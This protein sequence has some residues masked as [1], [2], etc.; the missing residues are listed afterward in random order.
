M[1]TL[2][3]LKT[4]LPSEGVHYLVTIR[5]YT[6]RDGVQRTK[7][8]HV[9]FEYLSA[10]AEAIEQA[11]ENPKPG[12]L[13]VYHACASYLKDEVD[14]GVW[15]NGEP[16]PA[17]RVPENHNR[18]KAIWIDIDCGEDKAAEGKG[19][20][21][22]RDAN[23]ALIEFC[24]ATSLPAPLVVDSGGGLHCYWPLTKAIRH[25]A[26]KRLS[27]AFK[28]LTQA[29]GLL[30]DPTA[31]AD[32]A[33]ILRPVGSHN[34]KRGDRR[35]VKAVNPETFH[36]ISP[37]DLLAAITKVRLDVGFVVPEPNREYS[38]S[39]DLDDLISKGKTEFPPF[40][41][42]TAAESCAQIRQMRDMRGDVSYDHWRGV[43]GFIKLSTDEDS[44]AHT[45][46][47]EREATGHAQT[48]VGAKL[49]S[50]NSGPPTCEYFKKCN[51]DGCVGCSFDGKVKSPARLGRVLSVHT[52]ST[53]L[54]VE[55]PSI[56]RNEI[57]GAEESVEYEGKKVLVE[58]PP[59]PTGYRWDGQRIV[60]ELRDKDG[61]P[62]DNAVTNS[63]MWAVSRVK[64][65]DHKMKILMR[66]LLN[67]N[68]LR[69]FYVGADE[70]AAGGT[71]LAKALGAYEIY[72]STENM[73]STN[74]LT[75]YL[76]D[77]AEN[78]KRRADE[79]STY[80]SYGWKEDYDLLVMGNK[81]FHRD[82][83]ERL[84]ILSGG[85]LVFEEG[86]NK[87]TGSAKGWSTAINILYN[88][89]GVEAFQY[90]IC[91]AFG[92]LLGEFQDEQYKGIPVALTST[93]SG[94]GKSTVCKMALYA[95]GDAEELSL[96]TQNG[97]TVLARDTMMGTLKNLPMLIDEITNID[98]DQLSDFLY[99]S[100]NGKSKIRLQS[101]GGAVTLRKSLSWNTSIFLT[102]N[103]R[104]GS[105]LA[106][107][108]A[109]STAEAV[110]V[111]EIPMDMLRA[112]LLEREDFKLAVGT[113][114]R[115]AGHAG[116][117]YAR[118]LVQNQETVQKYMVEEAGKMTGDGADIPQ[119]RFFRMHVECTIVA[120]R[121]MKEIG[122]VDFDIGA[123][124]TWAHGHVDYLCGTVAQ[125]NTISPEDAL[126]Q[127][128]SSMSPDILVTYGFKSGRDGSE[129]AVHRPRGE[130]VGR[131]ILG[132]RE[133]ANMAGQLYLS[134]K[135][136]RD[137]CLLNR[138]SVD[139]IEQAMRESGALLR[140]VDDRIR[141]TR[142]VE[143]SAVQARC[144]LIDTRKLPGAEA[145]LSVVTAEEV[146]A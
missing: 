140:L 92:S 124:R 42:E 78:L 43:I 58:I 21:T 37:E 117:D 11:D 79:V 136:V 61:L 110:R 145:Q 104:I 57:T 1:D 60:R 118:W 126:H 47:S 86:L 26:W 59:M 50:W 18:A 137:W 132:N 121:I 143:M 32:F 4:I 120:A 34:T 35:L 44:L 125:N 49:N 100:S 84:V 107:A 22:K 108:K 3:F 13:G 94:L 85:A 64:G 54:E 71:T 33:R 10:M 55:A 62:T 113:V 122:L 17:Y 87:R 27:A 63:R 56:T 146:A 119:Y 68:R 30:A 112:P 72:P 103:K 45:W 67:G 105:L 82:G 46:S 89:P 14:G 7:T 20:A 74:H 12:Q 141:I 41:A 142:G 80:E 90:A 28:A 36:Y 96:N 115:N 99:T 66:M 134:K 16:K 75:A 116:E 131:Y 39:S 24:R 8:E 77:E 139:V 127:M 88:R 9:P 81:A 114:K 25:Q 97:C 123:L 111:F 48:D 95:F 31:T 102:S 70:I 40:S 19:Y 109:D 106:S 5:E 133:Y 29:L 53:V 83:S 98:A 6:G 135:A 129:Q 38:G 76:R 15:P 144:Y 69:D 138:V 23:R 73:N 51:P 52:E 128:M 130:V 65:A 91:S 101:S 2:Q 93:A